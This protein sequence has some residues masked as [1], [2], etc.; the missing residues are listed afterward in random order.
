MGVWEGEGI[1]MRLLVACEFSGIVRDAFKDR[2]WD[3]WSC[4]LRPT[5]RPGN[6]IEGD[7]LEVLSDF[8][9]AMICHPC[10]RHLALS[11]AR[12]FAQ[13]RVDGRQQAALE[14]AKKLWNAP[15]NHI[16]LENPASVLSTQMC[17]YTQEIQ[18][19]QFGHG[20]V[21]KTWLWLKGIPKLQPTNIV[22]GRT[23]RVHMEPPGPERERRIEAELTL[24]LQRLWLTN[25][26]HILKSK[27]SGN[28]CKRNR[29]LSRK[30]G[31]SML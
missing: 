29:L 25:G 2:G 30:E 23:P 13:K 6:H 4:D 24:V 12:W 26:R 17:K 15:I 10:C 20:E 5:E 9:D 28:E 22:D 14:F 7:V 21:K 16:C 18:P 19:W 31:F 3:A 1:G 11:G 27:E 8:W